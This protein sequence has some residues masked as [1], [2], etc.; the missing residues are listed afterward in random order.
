MYEMRMSTSTRRIRALT[1]AALA[2]AFAAVV[3]AGGGSAANPTQ[4]VACQ[5]ADGKISGRGATFAINAQVL[6]ARGYR[7]DVCGPVGVFTTST[8]LRPIDGN[9]M[10]GYDYQTDPVVP[11]TGSGSGRT[12]Q[13]CRTDAFGM[14]DAPYTVAQLN[15]LNGA[16]TAP[17][18]SPC[19]ALQSVLLPPFAPNASPWPDNVASGTAIDTASALMSV[20][21]TGGSVA[22]VVNFEATAGCP[23]QVNLT[24]KMASQLFGGDITN[25]NSALL[26]TANPD[27]G[28]NLNPGLATCN[29]AVTRVVRTDTSGTTNIWK[30]FLTNADGTRTG[31]TCEDAFD[32]ARND[33]TRWPN[34]TSI[35]TGGVVTLIGTP[36]LDCAPLVGGTTSGNPALLDKCQTTAGAV[37]YADVAEASERAAADPNLV[38]ANIRNSVNSAFVAPAEGTKSLCD[39]SAITTPGFDGNSAIGLDVGDSWASDQL[40]A[41]GGRSNGDASFLGTGWPACGLTWALIYTGLSDTVEATNDPIN[42]LTDNQRRTLWSYM[43]YILGST[44]QERA[45]AG[46]Y[47]SLPPSFLTTF[48][49]AFQANY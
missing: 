6:F 49:S 18:A 4:G 24:T 22:A 34:V 48:R 17:S 9:S 29:L 7:D 36:D 39:F 26:R 46:F 42:R 35:S 2:G 15:T 1:V 23:S 40:D 47:A 8:D 25:W 45:D 27:G 10:V 5:V 30:N 31:A 37:C 38:L 12:S 14:S 20:P 13:Q 32:W 43:T 16:V 21:I 41:P 28:G 11:L 44:A 19:S 33:T 3:L